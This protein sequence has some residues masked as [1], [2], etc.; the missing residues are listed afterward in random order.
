[1]NKSAVNSTDLG[2]DP[3]RLE[4]NTIYIIYKK[5]TQFI[6]YCLINSFLTYFSKFNA[7]HRNLFSPSIVF[8]TNVDNLPITYG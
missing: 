7:A 4:N 5:T 6:S 1:M 3:K 8:F 2:P